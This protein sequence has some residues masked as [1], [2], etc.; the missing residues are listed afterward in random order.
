MKKTLLITSLSL[1]SACSSL[2]DW[3]GSADEAPL[4]GERISVID[5][6]INLKPDE[7]LAKEVIV[8]SDA[9]I[10]FTKHQ[11]YNIGE[12]AVDG[13]VLANPPVI[14]DGKLF[15]IDGLGTVRA[16]S[17]TDLKKLWSNQNSEEDEKELPG[18]GIA[19]ANG[20]IYATRGNGDV[21]AI[22]AENGAE[23]WK[24]NLGAAIRKNPAIGEDKVFVATADNQLFALNL[25]DGATVWRHSG[26][27]ESTINYGSP[28]PAIK[29]G[30]VVVAYSSGE[31]FA[32]NALRG[33]EVWAETI[34]NGSERR[35][36]SA[37]F[38]DVSATPLMVDGI[39]YV[40]SQNGSVIAFNTSNGFRI[41]EQ[42]T[43]AVEYTPTFLDKFLFLVADNSRVVAINR[44]DGKIKWVA[45]LPP[46]KNKKDNTIWAGPV[47]AGGS[48]IAA[49]SN[50][51]L[52]VF[53]VNTGEMTGLKDGQEDVYA[54]PLVS[55]NN[56]YL[57]SKNATLAVY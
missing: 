53:D 33:S 24:K 49:S 9:K 30:T 22:S 15:A 3:L 14:A 4:A 36:T 54:L 40:A 48:L 31:V 13:Y 41:W 10:D 7:D 5:S 43:G 12:A 6:S 17:Q 28:A 44:Y 46:K 51:K 39:T 11:T 19:Y 35:K 57:L 42:K 37:T 32:L 56:L 29:D 16:V 52:A 8:T 38:V 23:L 25:I 18:G 20:I 55:G 27:S 47:V 2:P 45:N 21:V 34:S 1:A 26:S 50:A